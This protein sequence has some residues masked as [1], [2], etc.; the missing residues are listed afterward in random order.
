[1]SRPTRLIIDTH[2]LVHNLKKIQEFAPQKKII[3]MV[4]ANAYGCGLS[5]VI[6]TLDGRVYA[7]GVACIEEA[8]DVR[9]LGSRSPCVL[10]QGVFSAEEYVLAAAQG[11]DCVLHQP[12]QVQWLLQTPLKHPLKVW[13]KVNTGMNRLGFRPHEIPRV[14]QTIK[15]CSWVA[16]QINLM[17]HFACADEP[18]RPENQQQMDAFAQINV[19]EFSHISMANSAA[20]MSFPDTHADVVRP[21]IMLYGVS[22]FADKIA[23]DL[24]L[25][26]VM[27]F[28]SALSAV[29]EN[30]PQGQVGYSGTWKSERTSRIGIVAVGYGDG[31]PRHIEANTPVW[32]QGAEVNIIGR[33]SM[34]MLAVD[35][36]NH[37]HIQPGT[38]V[39]L[40]GKNIAVERIAQKAGTS[41]YELL[42]QISERVRHR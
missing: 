20:I 7:F 36:T 19:Q 24:G 21:G 33:V 32:I 16:P 31:Y 37:P 2:A 42:C 26:P 10:F 29:Y 8:L 40:W 4:K 12:H 5:E 35:L 6:P 1:M 25:L 9:R 27:N 3:A 30:P 38:P 17:T 13:L 14:M 39:E 18:W 22:P 11:F 15:T 28:V 23:R 34:D 41:G